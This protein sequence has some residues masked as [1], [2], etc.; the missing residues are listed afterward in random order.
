EH[1][2]AHNP[3]QHDQKPEIP[4]LLAVNPQPLGIAHTHP[5]AHENAQGHQESIRGQKKPPEMN[6]LWIHSYFRCRKSLNYY[7]SLAGIPTVLVMLSGAGAARS[8]APA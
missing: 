5:H 4:S 3:A 1:L 8:T 7:L 2:S 6:Q